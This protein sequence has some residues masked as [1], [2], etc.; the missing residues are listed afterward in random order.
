MR[1]I[2]TW[3]PRDP[4][5][6]AIHGFFGMILGAVAGLGIHAYSPSP[7]PSILRLHMLVGALLFGLIAAL[8]GDE[9][10]GDLRRWWFP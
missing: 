4:L 8:Y 2:P 7:D 9:F 10:W 5:R 6:S 1:I 3:P